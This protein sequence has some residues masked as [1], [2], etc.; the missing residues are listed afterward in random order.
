[1]IAIASRLS[2]HGL[3]FAAVKSTVLL[4][5]IAC[6]ALLSAAMYGQME[7]QLALATGVAPATALGAHGILA[8]GSVGARAR[9]HMRIAVMHLGAIAGV[10][11]MMALLLPLLGAA[12]QDFALG[13]VL[14]IGAL[15]SVQL[16]LSAR[17]KGQGFGAW[18]SAVESS[19][20]LCLLAALGLFVWSGG[21]FMT[22]L[23]LLAIA[24]SGL[25]WWGL[26]R[27]VALRVP[28]PHWSR[29]YAAFVSA[30]AQFMTGGLLVGLFMAVPRASL[31]LFAGELEVARFALVFRWLSIAIVAHQFIATVFFRN[32]F[33][34]DADSGRDRA[35]AMIVLLVTLLAAVIAMVIG[36]GWLRHSAV[37]LPLPERADWMLIWLMA[38]AMVLWATTAALEGSMYRQQLA[39]S[40]AIAAAFGLTAFAV[41]AFGLYWASVDVVLGTAWA[42]LAGFVCTIV[43][44]LRR[45]VHH[46]A[47]IL[48]LAAMSTGCTVACIAVACLG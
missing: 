27:S 3:L 4:A 34:G 2:R 37:D 31:G 20:Y 17:L 9:R 40:Q 44:Q 25:L 11:I 21:G 7:W 15:V 13:P 33:A 6:A 8:Y 16:A 29:R 46:D 12:W 35:L 23:V 14:A 43:L 30:G 32:L 1:M 22:G 45:L 38:A 10:M 5:P 47:R 42:W 39:K 48:Q 26:A 24:A 41:A 28:G 19:L 18:A 36:S